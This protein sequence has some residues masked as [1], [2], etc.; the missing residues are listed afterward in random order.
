MPRKY[1]KTPRIR[2]RGAT[3]EP[4]KRIII[5]CEG[6]RTEPEYIKDFSRDKK[7]P[8]VEC[9]TIDGV[10]APKSI[11]DRAIEEKRKLQG[12]ARKSGNSFDKKHE[13]WCVSDVDEHPRVQQEMQR[14]TDNGLKYALSNPCI[15]LWGYLHYAQNDAPRH[16]HEMQRMLT[17]IMPGYDHAHGATFNYNDMRNG[18]TDAV[19][20][21]K[22]LIRRRE[23]ENT[24]HENPSTDIYL[25]MESICEIDE[26]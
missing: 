3:K 13:V 11:V 23:E 24:P 12:I 16:R 25:L 18:Y 6:R 7:H 1:P 9:I 10:G 15:E 4:K 8:L 17:D 19:T 5:I 26:D 14:A 2:R 21:A 22:E 20:R